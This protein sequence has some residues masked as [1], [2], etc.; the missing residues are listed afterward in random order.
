[1]GSA[2]IRNKKYFKTKV[3]ERFRNLQE[4]PSP[5]LEGTFQKINGIKSK[6]KMDWPMGD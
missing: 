4:V 6:R 1:M 3:R 2:F 5:L